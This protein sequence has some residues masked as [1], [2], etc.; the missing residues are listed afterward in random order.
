MSSE[1]R[2]LLPVR[3]TSRPAGTVEMDIG[4][5]TRHILVGPVFARGDYA[6]AG[7]AA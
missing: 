5:M 2:A 3:F 1:L 6:D 4:T 7:T